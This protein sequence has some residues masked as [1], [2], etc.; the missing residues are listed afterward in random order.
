LSIKPVDKPLTYLLTYFVP[1]AVET[2]GPMNKAGLQFLS[3]L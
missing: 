1:I 2:L 3:E